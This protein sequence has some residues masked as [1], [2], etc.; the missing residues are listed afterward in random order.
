MN[1]SMLIGSVLGAVA[2]TAGGAYATYSLVGG[3]DYA[4][5]VAV[6]AVKETIKTPRKN[7]VM[8]L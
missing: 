4:E 7:A 8:S 6:K 1:K 5:V 3:P 2:V